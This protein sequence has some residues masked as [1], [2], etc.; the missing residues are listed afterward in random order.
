MLDYLSTYCSTDNTN[1]KA[2]ATL[3]TAHIYLLETL[4][5]VVETVQSNKK[6]EFWNYGKASLV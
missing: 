1:P 6:S 5:E 4:N 2:L 3:V